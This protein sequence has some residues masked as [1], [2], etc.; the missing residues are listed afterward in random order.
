MDGSS[1][2]NM[3]YIVRVINLALKLKLA[4]TYHLHRDVRFPSTTTSS[5]S[6]I[7]TVRRIVF[8]G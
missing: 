6:R 7:V 3:Y 8:W 2:V 4:A 1:V 5:I